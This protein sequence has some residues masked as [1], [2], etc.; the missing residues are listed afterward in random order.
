MI[1]LS[2]LIDER[3]ADAYRK[4][5]AREAHRAVW[6]DYHGPAYPGTQHKG[7]AVILDRTLC[8][9]SG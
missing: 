5:T 6:G 7:I 3:I 8:G 9:E 2:R 4:A 1:Q